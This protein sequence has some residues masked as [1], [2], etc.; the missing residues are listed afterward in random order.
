MDLPYA[1]DVKHYWQTS[2][3]SPDV[4]VV[5]ARK[6]IEELAGTV[7]AEGF[8]EA[9]GHGAYMLA[10]QLKSDKFKVIWPVL[11]TYSGKFQAAKRQAATML[12]HDIKAKAM[13]ASVLGTKTAFFSYLMLTDGRTASELTTPEL[14]D[15]FPLQLKRGN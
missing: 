1:E 15:S 12:Y 7:L 13:A 14:I 3:T 6:L 2:T 10:F 9:G 11:P 4:W 8:G 5:R